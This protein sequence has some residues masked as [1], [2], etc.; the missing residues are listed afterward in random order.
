MIIILLFQFLYTGCLPWLELPDI[1]KLLAPDGQTHCLRSSGKSLLSVLQSWLK[2][3]GDFTF[4]VRGSRLGKAL[5]EQI[6]G[7]EVVHHFISLLKTR[8]SLKAFIFVLFNFYVFSSPCFSHSVVFII[9]FATA[10]VIPACDSFS[11]LVYFMYCMY[12]F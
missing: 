11:V 7:A 8:C 3:K 2:S 10:T 9:I 5:P 12:N 4:A 1:S 6:S